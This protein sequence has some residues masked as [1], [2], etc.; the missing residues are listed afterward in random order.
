MKSSLLPHIFFFKQL[1][2]GQFHPALK[3]QSKWNKP[4]YRSTSGDRAG[5]SRILLEEIFLKPSTQSLTTFSNKT[6]SPEAK[7]QSPSRVS[8]LFTSQN[9]H[10]VDSAE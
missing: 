4:V 2:I 7:K 10:S 1:K 8:E 6:S 5:N 3:E 9:R